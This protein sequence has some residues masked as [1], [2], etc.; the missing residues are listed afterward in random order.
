M[1]PEYPCPACGFLVFGEPP[2]SFAICP[3]CS[4]EDDNAQFAD[5][6]YQGGAN[7]ISLAEHR[8]GALSRFPPSVREHGG[9]RRDPGWLATVA[10]S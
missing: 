10:E 8:R 4:W 6:L 3:V 7:G 5:P 2:G 1:V 9:F